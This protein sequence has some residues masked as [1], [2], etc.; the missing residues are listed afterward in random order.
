MPNGTK[1]NL[2]IHEEG[3]VTLNNGT[4]G[5]KIETNDNKIIFITRCAL[6]H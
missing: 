2:D 3:Y 6:F 1:I 5:Y 4:K